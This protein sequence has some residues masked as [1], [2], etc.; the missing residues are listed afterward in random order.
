MNKDLDNEERT[1]YANFE[2]RRSY[3]KMAQK[4]TVGLY[5]NFTSI[6]GSS[7]RSIDLLKFDPDSSASNV[8]LLQRLA[9]E[10]E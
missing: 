1:A 5:S 6:A 7:I 3:I 10:N 2:K 9:D 8:E 4:G